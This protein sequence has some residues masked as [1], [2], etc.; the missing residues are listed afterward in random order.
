MPEEESRIRV[1]AASKA[2]PDPAPASPSIGFDISI[3]TWAKRSRDTQIFGCA[4]FPGGFTGL[5]FA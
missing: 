1:Y 2:Q 4:A 5:S 3:L